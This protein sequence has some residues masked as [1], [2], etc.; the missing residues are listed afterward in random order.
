MR[1]QLPRPPA[2]ASPSCPIPI[3]DDLS[4]VPRLAPPPLAP[5]MIQQRPLF[6]G[7]TTPAINLQ[8]PTEINPAL[9]M[10]K[11]CVFF[12]PLEKAAGRRKKLVPHCEIFI[13]FSS[14]SK[15][16]LI[17]SKPNY[18]TS[19][20]PIS[21]SWIIIFR[22][23]WETKPVFMSWPSRFATICLKS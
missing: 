7:R 4:R 9:L 1:L 16:E 2:P 8:T 22:F 11:V 12:L 10:D 14:E 20:Y 18:N 5:A 23:N 21:S 3:R 15:Y 19:V 6:S 17:T 13:K